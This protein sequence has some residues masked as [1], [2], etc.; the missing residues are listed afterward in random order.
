MDYNEKKHYIFY[1]GDCGFCLHWVHWIM[2][3]DKKDLFLFISLQSDNGKKFLHERGLGKS[4]FDTLYLWSP[5]NYY[6][7]KSDA[8]LKIASLLSGWYAIAV[9]F[10]FF[11]KF[12]SDYIYQQIAK[13]RWSIEVKDCEILSEKD[14]KK[15]I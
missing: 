4:E 1:D 12:L 5:G 8:V 3:R 9:K 15:F 10:N 11:P 14:Q 2:K 7:Q 13:K 6:L